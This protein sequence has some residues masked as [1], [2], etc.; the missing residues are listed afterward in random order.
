M[1]GPGPAS[2]PRA[3]VFTHQQLVRVDGGDVVVEGG[4]LAAVAR[5]LAG[6]D[7]EVRFEFPVEIEVVHVPLPADLD[8]LSDH[9]AE[10]LAQ[11]IEGGVV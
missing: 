8:A 9:I 1:P 11:R 3:H 4:D 5:P 6:E 2:R 7:G 10:L